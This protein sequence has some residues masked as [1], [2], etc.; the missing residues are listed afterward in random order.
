MESIPSNLKEESVALTQKSPEYPIII[1]QFQ[2]ITSNIIP[3]TINPLDPLPKNISEIPENIEQ[4]IIPKISTPKS[5]TAKNIV[6]VEDRRESA[7]RRSYFPGRKNTNK[8]SPTK[9]PE[10]EVDVFK[11]IE[12]KK[13]NNVIKLESFIEGT[14]FQILISLFTV[15]AL[16]GADLKFLISEKKDDEIFDYFTI[17]SLFI[18][19]FEIIVS[20][21]VKKDYLFSFFFFLDAISTITLIFD[22]TYVDSAFLY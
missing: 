21:I 5:E 9:S 18:F 17:F 2:E 6:I 1:T 16:F 8:G 13:S 3:E 19:C 14:P 20:V 22:L 4:H 15:Y 12:E 7:S 10:K 11:V